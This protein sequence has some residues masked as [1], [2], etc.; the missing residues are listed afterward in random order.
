[1]RKIILLLLFPIFHTQAQ[2]T[3]IE[4]Q[5]QSITTTLNNW[6]KAA[7]ESQFDTYFNLMTDDAIFIGT[8]PTEN[9]NLKDFKAFAKPYFD[10]E[11]AWNFTPLTRKIYLSPDGKTAW[12]DELLDT[13]M[14]I[15]RGSGTLLLQ[16]GH[17]KIAHYVLSITIPNEN[18]DEVVNIKS[19]F[20]TPLIQKLKNDK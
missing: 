14:K 20:E 7:A 9:W 15:C 3:P 4:K 18:T 5:K 1:M 6:H 2:S 19:P 11:K 17:W 16:K 12:F 13:Q 10:K 8:D